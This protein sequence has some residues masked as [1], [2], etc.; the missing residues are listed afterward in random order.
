MK[1]Q[2][3]ESILTGIPISMRIYIFLFI[4][5]LLFH[6]SLKAQE[7]SRPPVFGISAGVG[8]GKLKCNDSSDPDFAFKPSYTKMGGFTLEIPMPRLEKRGTFYNEINFIQFE[9][10]SSVHRPDGSQGS[11]DLYYYDVTQTFAPQLISLTTMFRYCFTN[12]AFK[13]YVS[14][15]FYNSFVLSCTNKKSTVHYVNGIP[16]VTEEEAV[17]DH[18]IHGLML[19]VGTG[20]YYKYAGLEFRYDPGRNYTKVIDYSVYN[21]TLSAVLLVRLNP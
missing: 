19:L 8:Y 16:N 10:N 13:Y 11:P 21:P 17:S 1:P 20:F 6:L 14:A 4:M 15:G 2:G 9:A 18:S 12:G 5:I 3:F 7:D